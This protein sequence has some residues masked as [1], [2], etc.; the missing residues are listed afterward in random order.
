MTDLILIFIFF[1]KGSHRKG[2]LK[3]KT[4]EQAGNLLTS[5]QEIPTSLFDLSKA[6]ACS[7][8]PGQMS[9]HHGLTVHGSEPNL[10]NRRRCGYVIRYV[11]TNSRPNENDPDR[12]R[13]FPATVLVSGEDDC[14]HFHDQ[15]P[16][17][18]TKNI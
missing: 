16:K 15:A 17:W 2:I 3:H 12:P 6:V 4:A 7:L 14:H 10:S 8:E 1:F 11:G 18:F 5:N 9:L 13:T